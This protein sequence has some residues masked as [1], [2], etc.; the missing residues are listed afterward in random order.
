MLQFFNGSALANDAAAGLQNGL[1][2]LIN[3]AFAVYN[4]IFFWTI[5]RSEI[6]PLC[7][8]WIWYFIELCQIIWCLAY[9]ISRTILQIDQINRFLIQSFCFV[10]AHYGVSCRWT[11][12]R[13][14]SWAQWTNI[15]MNVCFCA[16]FHFICYFFFPFCIII[17][18]N[19]IIF[20][21]LIFKD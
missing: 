19:S 4:S 20:E 6:H 10:L 18:I 17:L 5:R 3:F 16:V 14:S 9:F 13:R 2:R 11:K 7:F 21:R 12:Q 8:N 1:I 15:S